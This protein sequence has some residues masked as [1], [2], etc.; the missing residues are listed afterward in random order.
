MSPADSVGSSLISLRGTPHALD[1]RDAALH[2]A[3]NND[4]RDRSRRWCA[5]RSEIKEEPAAEG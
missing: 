3:L 2:E 1:T 4:H 5:L